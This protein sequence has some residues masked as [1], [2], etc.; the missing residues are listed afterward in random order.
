MLRD[1]LLDHVP[2]VV[3]AD[4]REIE[5]RQGLVQALLRMA[6]I[7]TDGKGEVTVR[8]TGG[9]VGLGA[10]YGSVWLQN[11]PSLTIRMAD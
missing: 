4:D 7:D 3:T 9:W 10:E 1:A 11:A 6:F 5:V 2:I 8:I